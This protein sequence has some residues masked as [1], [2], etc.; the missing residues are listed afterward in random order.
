MINTEVYG[1][2][3]TPQVVYNQYQ[4]SLPEFVTYYRTAYSLPLTGH[5][6]KDLYFLLQD[7][8][9]LDR[10]T[11]DKSLEKDSLTVLLKSLG[12][13]NAK[14]DEKKVVTAPKKVTAPKEV[15]KPS[16]GGSRKDQ[17]KDLYLSGTTSPKA[18]AEAIGANPS[19]VHRLLKQVK[20]DIGA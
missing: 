16:T 3:I 2:E 5:S 15:A 14:P 17:V 11:V 19:Y 4:M 9:H 10:L 1:V 20:D 12:K 13:K 8:R 6:L 18:I 7:E